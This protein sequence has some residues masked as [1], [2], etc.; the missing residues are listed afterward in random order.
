MVKREATKDGKVKLTFVQQ[1]DES[2]PALFV[3]GDFNNWDPAATKLVKRTNGTCS[4]SITVAAGE[5]IRF[6]YR[7]ADGAWSNDEAA[8]TYATGEAGAE[9]S[10]VIA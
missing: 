1:Y 7:D 6:R 3:L 2:K 5:E 4:A 8:D 9:N 10:I